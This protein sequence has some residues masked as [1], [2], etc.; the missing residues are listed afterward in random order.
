[1]LPREAIVFDEP[2]GSLT[3][4]EVLESVEIDASRTYWHSTGLYALPGEEIKIELLSAD[5][6]L[7]DLEVQIGAHK[8]NI[9]NNESWSRCPN[10]V[11]VNRITNGTSTIANPFGGPIYIASSVN[12][13]ISI[14]FVH[15]HTS[16]AKQI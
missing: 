7:T 14:Q 6:T 16:W 3:L 12:R 5:A 9:Q 4:D 13:N 11:F 1:M 2:D 10:I 15:Q 8:D